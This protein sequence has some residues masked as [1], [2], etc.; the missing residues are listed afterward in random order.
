MRKR[1]DRGSEPASEAP[2]PIV[3]VGARKVWES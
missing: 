2:F 1:S 3:A